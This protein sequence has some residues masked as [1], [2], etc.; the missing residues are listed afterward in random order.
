MYKYVALKRKGKDW[1]FYGDEVGFGASNEIQLAYKRALIPDY[2]KVLKEEGEIKFKYFEEKP[3][4]EKDFKNLKNS[5]YLREE[6]IVLKDK[7]IDFKDIK[8]FG[9]HPEGH[10]RQEPVDMVFRDKEDREV[11]IF[12]DR[13]I[14]NYPIFNDLIED[15]FM[16]RKFNS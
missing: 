4:N 13:T 14:S 9:Y 2:R 16:T 10:K 3:L 6:G 12:P 1:E 15:I 11:L 7:K 5:F 8:D